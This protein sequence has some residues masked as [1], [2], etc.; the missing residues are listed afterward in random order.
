[1]SLSDFNLLILIVTYYIHQSVLLTKVLALIIFLPFLSTLK[2]KREKMNH[3]RNSAA[4]SINVDL[5]L[6]SVQLT[7][8][9]FLFS[10]NNKKKMKSKLN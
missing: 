6:I 7:L 4:L 5:T 9:L 2:K 8:H 3:A 1:V 10:F